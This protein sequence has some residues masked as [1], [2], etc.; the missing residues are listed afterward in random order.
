M[1]PIQLQCHLRLIFLCV[2]TTVALTFSLH[3]SQVHAGNDE[4]QKI[5]KRSEQAELQGDLELAIQLTLQLMQLRPYD[6]D[7]MT[8]L[9]GLYG[10]AENPLKQLSWAQ[11]ALKRNPNY[12]PALINQGNALASTGQAKAAEESFR[13]AQRV[14]PSSPIPA[15]SM[16]VLAQESDE[17]QQAIL[18]F[19]EALKINPNF[20]DAMFNTAVAYANLKMYPE[21]VQTLDNLIKRNPSAADARYMRAEI[22]GKMTSFKVKKKN[23]YEVLY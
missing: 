12:F 5:Q 18:H 4:F 7:T 10:K 14:D 11:V 8:T 6:L 23:M 21:A 1:L 20:E 9:S 13:K 22:L 3:T 2:A 17:P 19:K 15:Y 16:G